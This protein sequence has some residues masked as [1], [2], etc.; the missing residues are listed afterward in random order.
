MGV[1]VSQNE[2]DEEGHISLM[3][4]K[5]LIKII[6]ENKFKIK[7]NIG[8]SIFGG[9]SFFDKHIT[10]FG[11]MILLDSIFHKF[12]SLCSGMIISAEK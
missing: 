5:E 10:I 7:S 9:N 8:N 2:W 6:K 11:I 3:N 12:K 4:N 1:K